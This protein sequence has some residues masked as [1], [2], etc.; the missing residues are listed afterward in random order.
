MRWELAGLGQAV[1][2]EADGP[3]RVGL[4]GLDEPLDIDPTSAIGTALANPLD[5]SGRPQVERRPP[6]A[7]EPG[8][9]AQPHFAAE[10]APSAPPP[11]PPS[12]PPSLPPQPTAAWPSAGDD[13]EAP[14]LLSRMARFFG[15][16]RPAPP[17]PTVPTPGSL[18]GG[19]CM[20][21]AQ[22][23][24]PQLW[25]TPGALRTLVRQPV[26]AQ[27]RYTPPKL[28]APYLYAVR[29]LGGAFDAETQRWGSPGLDGAD[30]TR[31]LRPSGHVV[32]FEGQVA[33]GLS[34]LPRPLY[35][36]LRAAPR[37]LDGT[38]DQLDLVTLPDGVQ[39]VKV[40]GERPRILHYEVE[41][42]EV[43]AVTQFRGNLSAPPQLLAPSLPLS[44]LPEEVQAF[45]A[46][47]RRLGGPAWEAALAVQGFVQWRY[48]YDLEFRIRP[49]VEEQ[50]ARQRPGRGNH[51]LQLLH[52][53]ADGT[54]LG[55]GT[56][57][58]LNML[59]VEL[60]RHLGVPALLAG[61]WALDLG[62]I[63]RPDHS[64]GLA[65]VWSSSGP[66]LLPVDATKG[67]QGPRR[68][69]P[70]IGEPAPLLTPEGA[71]PPAQQAGAGSGVAPGA[72]PVSAPP[73]PP[74]PGPWSADEVLPNPGRADAGAKAGA[75]RLDEALA[76]LS[77][78]EARHYL[79]DSELCLRALLL[80]CRKTDRAVPDEVTEVARLPALQPT[81]RAARLRSALEQV[82]G[83]TE[84]AAALLLILRC[85]E[86]Q[87]TAL[88]PALEALA[89]L[90]VLQVRAVPQFQVSPAPESGGS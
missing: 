15:I 67:P 26:L 19:N 1:E 20:E 24:E 4:S 55:R 63:D 52:A 47:R 83:D 79:R 57:F 77:A 84:Q 22:G 16:G 53:G 13:G 33:P 36:R 46:E 72:P 90:G 43:G 40:R 86:Q 35:S 25:A 31:G 21:P 9:E 71:R 28:P 50:A 30:F 29:A 88:S 89:G 11:S 48:A 5:G 70:G 85:G 23:I 12:L 66:C 73:V 6:V 49:E 78:A 51:H 74:V 75:A 61:G 76:E 10:P 59:V 3:L 81:E 60:L 44:K 17:A 80:V 69:L 45:V 7:T 39:G 8:A 87:V 41:L 65:V 18:L 38:A 58:E 54:F 37:L 42:L 68:L 62:W 14:G 56:C 34:V 32:I 64:F 2:R 82:L 27:L